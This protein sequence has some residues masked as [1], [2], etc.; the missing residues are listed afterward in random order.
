MMIGLRG[1]P[2]VQ[3]GVASV[4]SNR[5]APLIAELGCRVEVIARKP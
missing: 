2:N 3:G 4:T 1:C 5:L